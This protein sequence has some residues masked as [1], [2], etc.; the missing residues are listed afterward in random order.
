M[1]SR[2]RRRGRRP[3]GS[4]TSARVL[5]AARERFAAQGYDRRRIRAVAADAGVVHYFFM[6]RDGLFAAAMEL[7]LRPSEVL[8]PMLAGGLDGLGERIVRRPRSSG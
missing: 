4:D 6:T 7:P 1:S 5:A 8:G 2:S 3:G